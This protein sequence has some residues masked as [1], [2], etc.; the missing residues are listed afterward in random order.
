MNI[1]QIAARIKARQPDFFSPETMRFFGQTLRDYKVQESPMGRIF[2][3]AP[4]RHATWT[5]REFVTDFL[6]VPMEG[7]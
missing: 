3:Y 7:D 6:E 2:V 4:S 1:R 5:F